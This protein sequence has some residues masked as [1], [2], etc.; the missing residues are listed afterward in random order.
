MKLL[1]LYQQEFPADWVLD[2]LYNDVPKRA[3]LQ[4]RE[5]QTPRI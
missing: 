3:H 5:T 1:S 4:Q 2:R